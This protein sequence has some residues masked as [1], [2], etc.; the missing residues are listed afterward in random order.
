MKG[1]FYKEVGM[2][3]YSKWIVAK[4][5]QCSEHSYH[6]CGVE[7]FECSS[8][9][10]D[11]YEVLEQPQWECADWMTV[12]ENELENANYHS[13]GE[14]PHVFRSALKDSGIPDEWKPNAMRSLA[15][16]IWNLI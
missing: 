1:T 12:C 6:Y 9:G 14:L 15:M 7:D 4:C 11:Q 5:K 2:K 8:C 3:P 10:M 16:A 13:M